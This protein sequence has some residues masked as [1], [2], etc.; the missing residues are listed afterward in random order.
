M[1]KRIIP[2]NLKTAANLKYYDKCS[3]KLCNT[4]D[5]IKLFHRISTMLK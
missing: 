1:V 3:D 5:I 4:E 2:K